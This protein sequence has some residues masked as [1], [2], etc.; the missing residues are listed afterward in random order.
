MTKMTEQNKT[1][2]PNDAK[3]QC[4]QAIGPF[5]SAA[6]FIISDMQSHGA[7]RGSK[8]ESQHL[9]L[10]LR[11]VSTARVNND[12]CNLSDV[13]V[14][15]SL[16]DDRETSGSHLMVHWMMVFCNNKCSAVARAVVQV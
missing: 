16:R 5:A 12:R 1:S 15:H 4:G 3:N 6:L 2:H 11:C 9:Y 13:G 7:S 8:M 10:A 14:P